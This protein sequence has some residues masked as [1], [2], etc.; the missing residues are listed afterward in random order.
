MRQSLDSRFRGNDSNTFES[1]SIFNDSRELFVQQ[2]E[3]RL[4]S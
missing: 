4:L 2:L 1:S 3:F